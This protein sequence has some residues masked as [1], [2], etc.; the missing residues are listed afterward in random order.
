MAVHLVHFSPGGTTQKTVWNIAKG[1]GD[2][3]IIEHNMLKQENRTVGRMFSKDDVV[4]LGMPTATKLLGLPEEILACLQGDNTPLI[5][6]VMFGN[7]YF[8]NSLNLMK[9]AVAERGFVMVAGGAFIGQHPIRS[10]IATGRPDATDCEKQQAFGKAAAE[11][12]F[13][14]KELSFDATIKMDWPPNDLQGKIK[15]GLISMAPGISS[16]LPYS[17]SKLAISE[18]C[19]QCGACEKRC[20]VGAIHPATKFFDTERCIGCCACLKHCP[21]HAI[22]IKS[23]SLN[24]I[25]DNCEKKRIKRREPVTYL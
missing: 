19:I 12:I 1:M 3:E 4:I 5:G 17:W 15:C 2:V 25:L 16:T 24:K 8:G 9:K 10:Q 14:R 21:Q 22:S 11:K 6:V 7:G 18:D 23:S 13:I 20:P